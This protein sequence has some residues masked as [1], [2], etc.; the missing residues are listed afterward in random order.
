MKITD[1]AKC[2]IQT[3]TRHDNYMEQIQVKPKLVFFQHMYDEKLPKFLQLH[4]QEHIKCLSQFFEVTVINGD[5]DYLQI[6]DKYQPDLTIFEGGVKDINTHKRPKITSIHSNPHIPKLGLHRS[7][8]WC[9]A[10]S[11][12]LSDMD[13]WGIENFFSIA[14]TAAEHTPEIAD[15]LFIWPNFVDANIFRDYGE[16]KNIPVLFTGASSELYPWRRRILKLIPEYYPSLICPH[17]GYEPNSAIASFMVGERYVRTINSSIIVPSCG[18]VAKE[19]VRKHFEIPACKACLITE[20]SIGLEAAGFIHMTN[21]VFADEH[22]VLDKLDYLFQNPDILN[23]IIN[24]GYK[25]VHSRHTMAHRDQIF[26]WFNLHKSLNSNQR[27]VQPTPFEPL[28][29]VQNDSGIKSSHIISNGLHLTLLRHGDELLWRGRYSDA[30]QCYRNCMNYMRWMPEP[31]LRMALCSLYKGDAKTALSWI[32]E[33]INF[34]LSTYKATDPDPVE[35]AYFIITL[36]CLG[37]LD[38]AIKQANEF[39][40]LRH[41]E[42]DRARWAA[43]ALKNHGIP[44]HFS[45]D[46]T[47]KTRYSIHQLPSKSIKEW[48]VQICIMLKSCGQSIMAE[49]LEKCLS[50][51]PEGFQ[52]LQ[53]SGCAKIE[54]SVRQTKDHNEQRANRKALAFIKNRIFYRKLGLAIKARI[55]NFLHHLEIRYG[56]FLPY[57]LS[58]SRN[59]EFFKAIHELMIEEEIKTG[60]VIGASI[61]NYGTEAFLA[62]ASENKSSPSLFCISCSRRRFESL[63]KNFVKNSLSKFHELSSSSSND[64]SE[65]L[66]RI[67]KKIRDDNHIVCFDVVLING[68]ALK[69]ELAVNEELDKVLHSARFVLFDGI[70][71]AHAYRNYDGLFKDRQYVQVAC[72]PALRNGYAIFKRYSSVGG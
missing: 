31:R 59:D 18:T 62:G 12:F 57:F 14:T 34:I 20:K 56:Y 50:F 70:N 72:N 63:L 4:K 32:E 33:P 65:E 7:D 51:E 47:R 6:C 49:T 22:D 58:E 11:G 24:A 15:S 28:V 25:L 17:P 41:P 9:H 48:I 54:D 19:V 45:N 30:E 71:I 26:Q 5:C 66:E 68:S 1:K 46:Y 21:C 39:P 27:I 38:V 43:N 16:P 69:H 29:L 13:R 40:W 37:K 64:R 23:G 52:D 60:L 36:L 35:W 55:A 3:F 42:L 44:S 10:R 67:I 2:I 61:G 8:P 53:W